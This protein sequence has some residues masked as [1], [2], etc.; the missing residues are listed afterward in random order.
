MER[1]DFIRLAVALAAWPAVARAQQ[2]ERVR[3]I[4]ILMNRGTDDAEGRARLATF[5]HAMEQLG[6]SEG[7]NM[8][9]EIRWGEDDIDLE[10]KYAA[11]L[12]ALNPDLILASGTVSM[13]ALRPLSRTLPIVFAV[14]A[15]PVGAGFVN[16]LGWPAGMRPGFHSMNMV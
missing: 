12:V 7:R 4:A 8:E 13:T 6:W 16:S 11:E 2:N 1:R 5:K 15:D 9:I 3:R 14:V 10:R